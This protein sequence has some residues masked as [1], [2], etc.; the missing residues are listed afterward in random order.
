MLSRTVTDTATGDKQSRSWQYQGQFLKPSQVTYEDGTNAFFEYDIEG[1]ISQITNALGEVFNYEYGAF[2]KL[3]KQ[4]DPLGATT[5][6]HYNAI[7]EFAGVKNSHGKDWYYE[8]DTSG[9]IAAEVHYDNRRV[10]YAYDKAG[11]M[12]AQTKPDGT[13]LNYRYDI[14]GRLIASYSGEAKNPQ[15]LSEFEYDI[16]SRL[17]T[18]RN[19]DALV[20]Y[21]YN[22]LGQVIEE[23][24]N[25]HSITHQY[26]ADGRRLSRGGDSMALGFT[27]DQGQLSALQAGDFN[28]LH[29]AY[30]SFGQE[31]QRS[32]INGFALHQSYSATGLLQSQMA[33]QLTRHYQYD[34]LDRL[35]GIDDSLHGK[36]DYRYDAAGQVIAAQHTL[37]GKQQSRLFGYDSELNL[38]SIKTAPQVD[39]VMQQASQT[40]SLNY[41]NAGRVIKTDDAVFSYDACGRLQEKTQ[42]K[43]GFRPQQTNYHWDDDDRL[44][45]VTLADGERWHYQYDPFGR[46]IGKYK[47]NSK[48]QHTYDWEG[49]NL[50]AHSIYNDDEL[51]SKTQWLY[52]PNS[53]RPLA[54]INQ[55]GEDDKPQLSYIITDHAGTASELCDESG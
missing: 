15:N 44:I 25:G 8:F 17:V 12:L 43:N 22:A 53:F 23:S 29:F 21:E 10:T 31:T 38:N 11:Q 20:E 49:D 5:E 13:S 51:I 33:G 4:T 48:E 47:A 2:D 52:E 27:Y 37:G 9:R 46:R 55:Q 39:T 24:L 50:I 35:T 16:S 6:Y 36:T 19:D 18:A 7:A 1:N 34:A 30:N 14:L 41:D 28:P 3:A 26:D 32:S 42:H 45:G 40:Q 54:Q